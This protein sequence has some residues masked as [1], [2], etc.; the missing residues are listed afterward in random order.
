MTEDNTQ[1]RDHMALERTAL[2][3]ERTFLAYIRTALALFAAGAAFFHFFS[4]DTAWVAFAWLL[5]V[6]GAAITAVGGYRF[7]RLRRRLA[8]RSS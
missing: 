2:S 8:R 1:L 6:G 3:N 4:D 7:L 5:M